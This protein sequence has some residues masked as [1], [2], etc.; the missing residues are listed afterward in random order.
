MLC[1]CWLLGAALS[2]ERLALAAERQMRHWRCPLV[3]AALPLDRQATLQTSL[4]FIIANCRSDPAVILP[5]AAGRSR[6]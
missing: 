4:A 2:Q 1:S 6:H 5:G 3:G